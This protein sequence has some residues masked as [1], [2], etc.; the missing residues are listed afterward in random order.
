M[1]NTGRYAPIIARVLLGLVLVVTGLNKLFWFFPMPPMSQALTMFMNSLKATGYFLPFLGIVESVGGALL[2]LNLFVP[3][4]LILIAPVLV[5]ILGV[6]TFLDTRGLPLAVTL[7]ALELYLAWTYREG[8]Q[9]LF[10]ARS[11]SGNRLERK[12]LGRASASGN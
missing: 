7:I 11:L 10:V 6:H 3:L 2:L 9:S 5:N 1:P 4:A 12:E 8:F